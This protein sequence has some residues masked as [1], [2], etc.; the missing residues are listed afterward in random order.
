MLLLHRLNGYL[1]Y[2]RGISVHRGSIFTTTAGFLGLAAQEVVEGDVVVIVKGCS[3]PLL[4]RPRTDN[5]HT[6]CG[7]VFVGQ[8]L[9]GQ[10]EAIWG[11]NGIHTQRIS[12]F[13]NMRKGH[14]LPSAPPEWRHLSHIERHF[15]RCFCRARQSIRRWCLLSGGMRKTVWALI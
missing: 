7:L 11:A 10:L 13:N 1:S 2:L 6:F 3:F 12:F 4:L 14:V 5:A 15:G 9:S 8:L